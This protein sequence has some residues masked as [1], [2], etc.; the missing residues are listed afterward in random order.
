MANN[1]HPSSLLLTRTQADAARFVA[2][3]DA[4]LLATTE[5]VI[6]PLLRIE[7]VDGAVDL[8]GASAVIF[9]S[10]KAVGFA[11]VGAGRRAYCVGAVTAE[12]AEAK[13]WRVQQVAQT[14]DDLVAALDAAGPLVHLSGRHQ[15][16]DIAERLTARG[17]PCT[18]QVL[19]D[20][21]LQP[22]DPA[23]QRV[24]EGDKPVIVP[25]FSPRIAGQFAKEARD[26]TQAHVL[27][28][29][30]AVAEAFGAGRPAALR[31]AAEPTG[32]EMR[33]GVEKL[34]RETSLP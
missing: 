10:A 4:G 6:A 34:L 25:L 28:I 24:L 22:L 33:R 8:D 11:P 26:L 3:L 7:G 27:A 14:A 9:S 21:P 31:I 2:Q 13:G 19:Y 18:R 30:P 29:S 16:G 15:R 32:I 12:A 1:A 5:I 20:Q 23:A 17:I